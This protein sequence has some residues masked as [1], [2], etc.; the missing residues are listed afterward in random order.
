MIL[1][2]Y[3]LTINITMLACHAC[4][5]SFFIAVAA[6]S[7]AYAASSHAAIEGETPFYAKELDFGFRKNN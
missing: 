1:G 6:S 4:V 7:L 3:L 5:V 2:M